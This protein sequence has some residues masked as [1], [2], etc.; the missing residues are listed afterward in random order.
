MAKCS[1]VPPKAAREFLTMH[2]G[3]PDEAL[4]AIAVCIADAVEALTV[5]YLKP[6]DARNQRMGNL[7]CILDRMHHG[8]TSSCRIAIAKGTRGVLTVL[9]ERPALAVILEAS[10]R[11][12]CVDSSTHVH[13]WRQARAHGKGLVEATRPGDDELR[14]KVVAVQHLNGIEGRIRCTCAPASVLH[15]RATGTPLLELFAR[16]EDDRAP[17]VDKDALSST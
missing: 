17:H 16:L 10:A 2:K 12:R 14:N 9:W 7:I 11:E 5:E 13:T 3:D 1:G 4:G 15:E 6:E 8:H